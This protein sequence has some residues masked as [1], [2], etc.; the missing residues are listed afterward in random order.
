MSAGTSGEMTLAFDLDAI[1]AFA[2]PRDVFADAR[3]WSRYVGVV[4]D[5]VAAAESFLRRC[6]L[7]QD[8]DL[9]TLPKQAILSQLKWEADT[10][11]YVY[12]GVTDEHR[13]LAEYVHW[14]YRPVEL[15]ADRT[16]WTL[17]EDASVLEQTRARIARSKA[18]PFPLRID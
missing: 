12:V 3:E 7:Q 16:G 17:L 9:G 2:R 13:S 14:E 11:R 1:R 4:A 6:G 10:D 5:D 15:V 8:Y 18:W